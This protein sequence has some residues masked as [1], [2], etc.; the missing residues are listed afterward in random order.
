ML[1]SDKFYS[2]VSIKKLKI[3]FRPQHINAGALKS[4]GLEAIVGTHMWISDYLLLCTS[5]HM[6]ASL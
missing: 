1:Q 4:I 3:I 6:Q 5:E 2:I